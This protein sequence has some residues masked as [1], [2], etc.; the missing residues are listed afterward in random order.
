MGG[1]ALTVQGGIVE[2]IRDLFHNL[3]NKHNLITIGCG[4][5]K[6]EV[7]E[8]IKG[9]NIDAVKGALAKVLNNLD[10]LIESAV[11]ADRITNE[12]HDRIYKIIDPDTGKTKNG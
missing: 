6:E 3:G 11:E 9:K 1:Y 5:T 10:Q 4:A 12:I 8:C 7:E 2:S